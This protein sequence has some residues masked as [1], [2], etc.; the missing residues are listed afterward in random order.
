MKLSTIMTYIF[1]TA[2]ISCITI[3]ALHFNKPALMWWYILP[4]FIAFCNVVGSSGG[5]KE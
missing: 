5:S 4:A 2:F 1:V 3:A